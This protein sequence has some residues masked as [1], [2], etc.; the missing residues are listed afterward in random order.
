MADKKAG[1]RGVVDSITAL[2]MKRYNEKGAGSLKKVPALPTIDQLREKV[3][4]VPAKKKAKRGKK[5]K[6]ARR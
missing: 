6:G 2:R 5:K 1:D 3:A 4:K